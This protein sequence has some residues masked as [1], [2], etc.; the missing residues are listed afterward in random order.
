MTSQFSGRRGGGGGAGAVPT[1]P[2]RRELQLTEV[3]TGTQVH[4]T[5]CLVY[6]CDAMWQLPV[7]LYARLSSLCRTR[8]VYTYTG[9]LE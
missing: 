1:Q 7:S 2:G 9:T 3:C 6:L 8:L 5:S 4:V